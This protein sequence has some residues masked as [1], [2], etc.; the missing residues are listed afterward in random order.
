MNLLVRSASQM[1]TPH[2]CICQMGRAVC[3][4]KS[5]SAVSKPISVG[6][7][8]Q[9]P[10]S[11]RFLNHAHRRRTQRQLIPCWRLSPLC[12]TANPPFALSQTGILDRKALLLPNLQVQGVVGRAQLG[13]AGNVVF[14]GLVL[15]G[16]LD[17][18]AR[19]WCLRRRCGRR[20]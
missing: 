20:L 5:S 7:V 14:T 2:I 3:T 16:R 6:I 1:G 11:A 19:R 9:R 12:R 4:Y 18:G 15:I 17:G 8:P 13:T 10:S